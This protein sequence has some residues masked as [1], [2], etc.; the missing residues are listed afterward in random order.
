MTG[1]RETH[2]RAE[3]VG[4]GQSD[5]FVKKYSQGWHI[6]T[7]TKKARPAQC[8]RQCS[9]VGFSWKH[10]AP[11]YGSSQEEQSSACSNLE[12]LLLPP[13]HAA[14]NAREH[15]IVGRLVL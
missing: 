15:F 14:E 9:G 8:P 2:E 10:R 13:A 3:R 7:C 6:R 4:R 12:N 1:N 5:C 11:N